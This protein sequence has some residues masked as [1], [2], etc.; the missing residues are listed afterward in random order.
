[1]ALAPGRV[2]ATNS[3]IEALWPDGATPDD[4]GRAL[5]YRVWHLRN[6]LEPDRGDRSE[7]TLVL[8]RP[9]GYLLALEPEAVDAV[10][11]E[12][13][14]DRTRFTDDDPMGRRDVLGALLESWYSPSF[15]ESSTHG[16]LADAAA[17]LDRLRL[18]VLG[19]IGRAHV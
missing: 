2:V 9:T 16:P 1:M 14:W 12:A 10:R 18:S 17:R 7:G 15:A 3:L 13:E 11:L 4:P 5:R 8:T 19:E 6:L